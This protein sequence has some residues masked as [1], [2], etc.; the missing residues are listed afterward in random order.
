MDKLKQLVANAISLVLG[1][2]LPCLF[3]LV[4][5]SQ[6]LIYCGMLFLLVICF[7]F[8]LAIQRYKRK[9]KV[10]YSVLIFVLDLE[11]KLLIVDNK[12]HERKMIPC[13]RIGK[14]QTPLGAVEIFL[15]EQAGIALNQC[16]VAA[17]SI[18]FPGDT[19][20][21]CS[22]QLEFISKHERR[23]AAHYAFVYFLHLSKDESIS[24]EAKFMSLKELEDLPQSIELF[25]DILQR[26]RFYL[27][28]CF[29]GK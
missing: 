19:W 18:I 5:N 11:G 4:E 21:P 20:R 6:L 14:F 27:D 2:L 24:N 23:F 26:Y 3:G 17:H 8:I 9:H 22:A 12:F 13:G 7:A 25:S 29:N 10:E 1:M 15:K 28:N 16:E